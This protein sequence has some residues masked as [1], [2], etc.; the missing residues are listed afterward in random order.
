MRTQRCSNCAVRPDFLAYQRNQLSDILQLLNFGRNEPDSETRFDSNH[1]IDVI[2][3]IP[4]FDIGFVRVR[5]DDQVLLIQH[6]S[7]NLSNG[8]KNVLPGH[9]NVISYA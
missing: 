9:A 6:I 7:N 4:R 1:D 2:E 5:L 8:G 3:R